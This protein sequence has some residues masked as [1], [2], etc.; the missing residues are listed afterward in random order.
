MGGLLVITRAFVVL[1][2]IWANHG[3]LLFIF[4]LFKHFCFIRAVFSIV[5]I[6]SGARI[7]LRVTPVKTSYDEVP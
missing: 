6:F 2:K 1:V 5:K 7:E 4:V 3:L